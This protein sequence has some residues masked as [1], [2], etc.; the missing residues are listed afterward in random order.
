MAFQE[1]WCYAHG[2]WSYFPN[3]SECELRKLTQTH[4]NRENV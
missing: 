1:V 3:I 4:S 2:S